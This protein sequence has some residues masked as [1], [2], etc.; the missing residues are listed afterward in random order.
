MA[1]STKYVDRQTIIVIVVMVRT[2]RFLNIPSRV[3]IRPVLSSLYIYRIEKS[4]RKD[5]TTTNKNGRQPLGGSVLKAISRSQTPSAYPGSSVR[6]SAVAA[7]AFI[8]SGGGSAFACTVDRDG[9]DSR[10]RS[11]SGIRCS[12]SLVVRPPSPRPSGAQRFGYQIHVSANL[13]QSEATLGAEL[14]CFR[15]GTLRGNLDPILIYTDCVTGNGAHFSA[16]ATLCASNPH[17]FSLF[18]AIS[19]LLS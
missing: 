8:A 6:Q 19:F 16:M 17:G 3:D 7:L 13:T 11:I 5:A 1:I 4:Y 12:R 14:D 10:L 2:Q 9:S 18:S 15:N